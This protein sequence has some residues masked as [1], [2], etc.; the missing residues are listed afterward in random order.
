MSNK[1]TGVG[2]LMV[3]VLLVLISATADSIGLGGAAGFG[4]KQGAGL[5]LGVALAALGMVRL[6]SRTA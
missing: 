2:L 1:A 5:V 3:G 4:W 6:R